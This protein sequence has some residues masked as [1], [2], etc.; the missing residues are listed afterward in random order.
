[1]DLNAAVVSASSQAFLMQLESDHSG[2]RFRMP[3]WRHL[4]GPIS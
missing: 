2:P 1:V 4:R 3:V